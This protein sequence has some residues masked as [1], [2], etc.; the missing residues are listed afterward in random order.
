MANCSLNLKINS[1]VVSSC[2]NLGRTLPECRHRNY[3]NE[4]KGTVS[5]NTTVIFGGVFYLG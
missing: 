4:E 5:Q 1:K 2:R 3:A